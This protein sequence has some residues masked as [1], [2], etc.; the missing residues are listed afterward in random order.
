MDSPRRSA[1]LV[2]V[3][4]PLLLGPPHVGRG[5]TPDQAV[6]GDPAA[7]RADQA[8]LRARRP[9]V[10]TAPTP[11]LAALGLRPPQDL[12]QAV[13]GHTA[14]APTLLSSV[15]AA[16]TVASDATPV[17]GVGYGGARPRR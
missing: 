6:E 16:V 12:K 10:S 5:H 17:A 1:R 2:P 14:A 7:R 8:A 9:D 13:R 11:G 4:L 15:A 3:V